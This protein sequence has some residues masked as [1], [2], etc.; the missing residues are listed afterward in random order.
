MSEHVKSEISAYLAGGLPESRCRQ[1]ESHVAACEK[2]R[3]ALTKARTKQARIKREALKRAAP[4]PLP[5]LFLARLGKEAG[6]DRTPKRWP[7]IVAGAAVAVAAALLVWSKYQWDFGRK[8]TPGKSGAPLS[9]STPTAQVP[10]AQDSS[11]VLPSTEVAKSNLTPA[12]PTAASSNV[13]LRPVQQW[14]G[15]DCAVLHARQVVIQDAGAWHGLWQE[16][17]EGR[18]AP[19]LNFNDVVAI[20]IFV[21]ERP[22]AGYQVALGRIRERFDE[23]L[24]FYRVT[25]PGPEVSTGTA[26]THP[27]LLATLPRVNKKIRFVQQETSP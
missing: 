13:P 8:N 12:L 2:C 14:S 7:W 6:L 21:G 16:M 17:Q 4:E 5:N 24:V 15:A 22:S 1:I 25:A 11:A 20:G 26:A 27:Y 23:C 19:A 9:V 3:H 18:P 10:V